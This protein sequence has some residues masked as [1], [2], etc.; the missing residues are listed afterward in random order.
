[1]GVRPEIANKGHISNQMLLATTAEQVLQGQQGCVDAT[2]LG[3]AMNGVETLEWAMV[4]KMI[5]V[6]L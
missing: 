4:F 5:M 2:A 3:G 6:S 1:M